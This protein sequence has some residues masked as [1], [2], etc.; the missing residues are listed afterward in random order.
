MPSILI[1]HTSVYWLLRTIS[2]FKEAC[3]YPAVFAYYSPTGTSSGLI[4]KINVLHDYEEKF[5]SVI[6]VYYLLRFLNVGLFYNPSML[7]E[8]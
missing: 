8:E 3:L 1:S 2:Y 5:Y 7:C 4:I 6:V